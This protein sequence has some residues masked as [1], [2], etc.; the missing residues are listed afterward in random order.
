MLSCTNSHSFVQ[1]ILVS[2]LFELCHIV[3]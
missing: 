3:K 1:V 2:K